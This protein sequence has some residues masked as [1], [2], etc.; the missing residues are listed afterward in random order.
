MRYVMISLFTAM[1]ISSPLNTH[2]ETNICTLGELTRKVTVV[3]SDPGQVVPCEVLYEK[4]NEVESHNQSMTLWRAQN[5]AGFCEA[6]A[7]EFL[8]KL[9][10]LGWQC[11]TSSATSTPQ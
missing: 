3:Y 6:K 2:A 7:S 9:T 8:R 10:N 11:S 1:A 5:E 4:P